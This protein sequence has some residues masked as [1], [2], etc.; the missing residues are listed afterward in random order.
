VQQLSHDQVRDLVVNGRAKEDDALIE[1]T[2]VDVERALSARGLLDD[3]W[4]EWAHSPPLFRLAYRI[5]L[6]EG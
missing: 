3:H 1:Q 2:A 4:N 5:P 6:S